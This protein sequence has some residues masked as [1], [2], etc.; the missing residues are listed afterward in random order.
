[1]HVFG[2]QCHTQEAVAHRAVFFSAQIGAQVFDMS[3]C[4]E[5]SY[6]PDNHMTD[7]L[8]KALQS[9]FQE[10][11]IP[12]TKLSCNGANIVAT[13]RLHLGLNKAITDHTQKM[14]RALGLAA[15]LS[16]ASPIAG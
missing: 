8:A 6:L 1:M 9:A 16:D 5:S 10:W 14:S 7:N 4:L 2:G 12:T 3:R 13:T 11:D 15:P